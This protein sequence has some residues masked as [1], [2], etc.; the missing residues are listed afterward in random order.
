MY[1]QLLIVTVEQL[2]LRDNFKGW[3]SVVA[4]TFI[5][6]SILEKD[7]NW[8]ILFNEVVY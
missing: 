3:L 5:R 8:V 6:L 2:A 1:T 4:S 7:A